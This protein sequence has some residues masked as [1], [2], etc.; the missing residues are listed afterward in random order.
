MQTIEVVV[1]AELPA[2]NEIWS[3]SEA[4][5]LGRKI[6]SN[7]QKAAGLILDTAEL[8]LMAHERFR[9]RGLSVVLRAAR[10]SKVDFRKLVGI[11]RDQR[12]RRIEALL[13]P[14]FSIIYEVSLLSVEV[15]NEAVNA[16]VIHP[17]VRRAEIEALR[18]PSASKNNG[19]RGDELPAA[20]ISAGRRYEFVVPADIRADHCAQVK[21]ALGAFQKKF[22]IQI[23][24]IKE[25]EA[26]QDAVP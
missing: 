7:W 12:L 18:K 16:G 2:I 24:S 10:I 4:A 25:L 5:E 9:S 20:E 11:G 3:I 26:A 6:G 23:I 22:G 14:G 17:H 19:F 21:Q 1:P 8:C 15:F 13:P